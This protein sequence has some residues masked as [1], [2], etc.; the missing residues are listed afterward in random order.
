MEIT[1]KLIHLDRTV[2]CTD[3]FKKREFVVD[4]LDGGGRRQAIK[5]TAVQEGCEAL[6]QFRQN[7][8]ICIGFD[9]R[10][11][12]YVDKVTGEDKN[13]T[14]LQSHVVTATQSELV[15]QQ[16]VQEPPQTQ[17]PPVQ[18]QQPATACGLPPQSSDQPPIEPPAS[19]EDFRQVP[20]QEDIP[21]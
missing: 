9:L 8:E 4:Y 13:F 17:T 11:S 2:Q 1:G 6:S 21:F 14:S 7:E 10:G 3:T 15:T 19:P 5:F 16:P 12:A 20:P 18:Y